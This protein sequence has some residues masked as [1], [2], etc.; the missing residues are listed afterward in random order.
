M[1]TL[2]RFVVAQQQER[3]DEAFREWAA[4]RAQDYLWRL[5][6][7]RAYVVRVRLVV[8]AVV[9]VVASGLFAAWQLANVITWLLNN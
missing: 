5:R 8:A 3:E 7:R 1:A 9:A 2:P 6:A 4:D